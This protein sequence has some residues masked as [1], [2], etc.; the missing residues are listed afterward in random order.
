MNELAKY[1]GAFDTVSAST[2]KGTDMLNSMLLSEYESS[3]NL[4]Q[5]ISAFVEEMDLLFQQIEEVY[6]GRFI[7]QAVGR[8]LDIIGII[9]NQSRSVPLDILFFG[10]TNAGT[11]AVTM[12]D[13]AFADEAAPAAGGILKDESQLGFTIVPLGDVQYRRLLMAKAY[14]HTQP[15][16]DINTAYFAVSTLLGKTP[17]LLTLKT[18]ASSPT[19]SLTGRT[20]LMQLSEEDTTEADRSLVEFFSKYFVPLGTSFTVTR[21]T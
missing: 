9:L 2:T 10:F 20:V 1:G 18:S 7:E 8:Q 12:A 11:P 4:I 19:A 6:L 16:V 15:S 14:L 5:Y 17:R 13:P 21:I 3:P